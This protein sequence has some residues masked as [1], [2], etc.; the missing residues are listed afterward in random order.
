MHLIFDL[1]CSH[2]LHRGAAELFPYFLCSVHFNRL[3]GLLPSMPYIVSLVIFIQLTKPPANSYVITPS[4]YY[5]LYWRTE[6][7]HAGTLILP[8]LNETSN[9]ASQFRLQSLYWS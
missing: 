1:T 3:K 5:N 4:I 9:L 2:L 8:Y 7:T 6:L